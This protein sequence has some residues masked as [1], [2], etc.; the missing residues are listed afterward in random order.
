MKASSVAPLVAT[1]FALLILLALTTASAY[2]NLGF[3]NT[4][5][6]LVI[7]AVKVGLIAVFFMHLGQSDGAVR[8]AAA[9]ALFFLFILAFL[10][11]SD[12]LSRPS[13]P[14]PWHEPAREPRG[15]VPALTY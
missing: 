13:Q 4:L 8:I 3:G 15:T 11:F 7:A 1:W 10:S 5:L 9:A 2:V 6:N 12:I 14:A